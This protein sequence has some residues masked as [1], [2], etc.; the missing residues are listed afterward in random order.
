MKGSCSRP[1]KPASAPLRGLLCALGAWRALTL[2]LPLMLPLAPQALAASNVQASA[3]PCDKPVY[4]T[5]D[6]GHMGVAPLVAEVLQRQNVKATFFLANEKT[7]A[8]GERHEGSTLDDQW[9]PWWK[10]LAAQGHDFGSHTWNHAIWRGDA[11]GGQGAF[12]FKPTAGERAGQVVTMTARE[13]CEELARPARRFEQMTGQPMRAIFRSAG[14]KTSPG[15]LAAAQACGW[16]HVPW[17][18]AGFLG[19]ELPSE[20]YSNKLLLER[21]LKSVQPGDI[22]LMH[23]G[24]WSRK[25][26]WAPTVL[27]PLIVGLKARGLCFATLKAHPDYASVGPAPK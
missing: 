25:D 21:A 17:S 20:A 5:I 18:S 12:Q 15:L 24:I 19:D 4:L 16:R 2:I 7:M 11:K 14:G 13:Y 27:E 6:T 9:A 23:L 22:L 3:A 8:V 10:A 1:L 26:P